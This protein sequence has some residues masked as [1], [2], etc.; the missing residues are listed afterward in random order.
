MCVISEKYSKIIGDTVFIPDD[1]PNDDTIVLPKVKYKKITDIELYPN[2]SYIYYGFTD[3]TDITNLLNNYELY[4]IL[5]YVYQG[6]SL[7]KGIYIKTE[8][9]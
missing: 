1:I 6:I 4:K 5:E 2:K 3:E 7:S 8:F 9:H